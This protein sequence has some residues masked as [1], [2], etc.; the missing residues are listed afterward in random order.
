[1]ITLNEL[2]G[3]MVLNAWEEYR[4][5]HSWGEFFHLDEQYGRDY[6]LFRKEVSAQALARSVPSRT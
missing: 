6:F 4:A 3:W 2:I 1:M 5:K